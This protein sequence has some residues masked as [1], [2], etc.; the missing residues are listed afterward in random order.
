MTAPLPPVTER[1]T[2]RACGSPDL[3]GLFSFGNLYVSNFVTRA[4]VEGAYA[5][6]PRA[7]LEL[8]LCRGCTLVQ[9]RHTAPQELLYARRYWYRSGTTATMRAA[10]DDVVSAACTLVGL[11]AGDVV[12]DI[13]S[14]DGTL[15]R[16]EHLRSGWAVRVGVEPAD[17]LAVP[18]NYEGCVLLH[19]FWPTPKYK[20]LVPYHPAKVVFALGMFYDLE[21]PGAF[22]RGV[23]DVLHP[24]G[25]F[26]AQLMCLRQTVEQND[27][28]N[29]CHEHLEYYTLRSLVAMYR[30][31]GLEIFDVEQNAV[32]GGSYRLWAR[33]AGH[34]DRV[35]VPGLERVRAALETEEAMGLDNPVRLMAWYHRLLQ[36]RHDVQTLVYQSA[37]AGRRVYGYGASTKGNT[38]LQWLGLGP[39]T[40]LGVADK[41]EEK[42]GRYTVGTGIPIVSEEAFRQS[43]PDLALVLPYAFRDEFLAR[44]AEHRWRKRGGRFAFPL[45]KLEVV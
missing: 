32:N 29:V 28:G 24:E 19:D 45:P 31:A 35:G 12:L 43:D 10:L 13:G 26:V 6:C 41:A 38:L 18:E 23:A 20:E 21:D 34:R 5:G 30:A 11:K 8:V 9:L 2:C 16:S 3:H 37:R 44:E 25:V 17:N 36:N 15:L 42:W 40:V 39:D 22:V 1:T 7:P 4:E 33:P 27:V 14:N